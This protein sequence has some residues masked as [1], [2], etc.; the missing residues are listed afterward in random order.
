MM[1]VIFKTTVRTEHSFAWHSYHLFNS[2]RSVIVKHK[3]I[4]KKST[5][6]TIK[7]PYWLHM[8]SLEELI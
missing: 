4:Y 2:N 3:I 7:K 6:L 5:T 8:H 1:E